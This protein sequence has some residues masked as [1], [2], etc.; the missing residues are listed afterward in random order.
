ME[1]VIRPLSSD[2]VATSLDNASNSATTVRFYFTHI[3]NSDYQGAYITIYHNP[4]DSFLMCES[5]SCGYHNEC[6][7]DY[8]FF[9]DLLNNHEWELQPNYVHYPINDE[10]IENDEI[11]NFLFPY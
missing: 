5:D 7:V 3:D 2:V 10:E 6:E 1:R 8:D 11:L 9:I 4:D